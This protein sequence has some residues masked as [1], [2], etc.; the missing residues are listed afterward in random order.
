M[1]MKHSIIAL[2]FFFTGNIALLNGMEE[3]EKPDK[4][5]NTPLSFSATVAPD[6]IQPLGEYFFPNDTTVSTTELDLDPQAEV[7][8]EMHAEAQRILNNLMSSVQLE[9]PVRLERMFV[10]E[11]SR[12]HIQNARPHATDRNLN[13][14]RIESSPH[15]M[16]EIPLDVAFDLFSFGFPIFAGQVE[17]AGTIELKEITNQ[18]TLRAL[19]QVSLTKKISTSFFSYFATNT[20]ANAQFSNLPDLKAT[21]LKLSQIATCFGEINRA[22]LKRLIKMK[23]VNHDTIT[24]LRN[25]IHMWQANAT[26][27]SIVLPSLNNAYTLYRKLLYLKQGRFVETYIENKLLNGIAEDENRI[28]CLMLDLLRPYANAFL[29]SEGKDKELIEPIDWDREQIPHVIKRRLSQFQA[30]AVEREKKFKEYKQQQALNAAK[31]EKEEEEKPA[32]TKKKKRRNNQRRNKASI[33]AQPSTAQVA[34]GH[35]TVTQ[36]PDMPLHLPKPEDLITTTT[37][38]VQIAPGLT[39][40]V[41]GSAA[42]S[43]EEQSPELDAWKAS[44][45]ETRAQK[46]KIEQQKRQIIVNTHKIETAK[47]EQAEAA[48]L[49][50]NPRLLALY[51]D[52]RAKFSAYL[53]K[54]K[55]TID[56][57]YQALLNPAKRTKNIT[58]DDLDRLFEKLCKLVKTF[59]D[60]NKIGSP[61]DRAIFVTKLREDLLGSRHNLH[62]TGEGEDLPDNYIVHRR[63]ALIYFGL[64]PLESMDQV[65][66]LNRRAVELYSRRLLSRALLPKD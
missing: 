54:N 14:D 11:H 23:L 66:K 24:S 1:Y 56:P 43:Q 63:G 35:G 55:V 28:V 51:D 47:K 26:E 29:L 6:L 7:G 64:V 16:L 41:L 57:V 3:R 22:A 25:D 38:S 37:R 15:T 20:K 18:N 34:P 2:F 39:E 9:E 19:V 12:C 65:S 42:Q 27:F 36:A 49:Q 58:Q 8:V 59:L 32:P 61:E 50:K 53:D 60:E 10:R 31:T 30:I 17:G 48:K 5:D 44:V 52:E 33:K 21:F 62:N 4:S 40:I 13:T 45:S 46:A